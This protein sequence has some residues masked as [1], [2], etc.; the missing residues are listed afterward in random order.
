MKY[1]LVSIHNRIKTFEF[2]SQIS[3]RFSWNLILKSTQNFSLCKSM[4]WSIMYSEQQVRYSCYKFY[5]TYEKCWLRLMNYKIRLK[6][7]LQ[8]NFVKVLKKKKLDY[9]LKNMNLNNKNRLLPSNW[10]QYCIVGY[11][12]KSGNWSY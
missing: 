1:P 3:N 9:Q 12:Y 5:Y 4:E 11:F 10:A 2:Y 8:F 6:L 7:L